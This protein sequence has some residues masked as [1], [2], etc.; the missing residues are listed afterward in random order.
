MTFMTHFSDKL[1]IS[2]HFNFLSQ[3]ITIYDKINC[4]HKNTYFVYNESKMS[5][6]L[7]YLR[8][9]MCNIETLS[10]KKLIFTYLKAS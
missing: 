2:T 1:L 4:Y 7:K 8:Y 9:K 3:F 5:Y 10:I 6:L